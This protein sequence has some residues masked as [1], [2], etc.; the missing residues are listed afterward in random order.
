MVSTPRGFS[1]I[2]L[3]MALTITLGIGLIVFQLF[4][5]N[6]HVFRDQ[7][8]IIEM[9]QSA[10]AVASQIA[11][12]IRMA[13]TGIPIYA[14]IADIEFEDAVA[15]ILPTSTTSRID[16]RAGL[17]NVEAM[18]TTAAPVGLAIGTPI[19]LGVTGASFSA[20]QHVYLWGPSTPS[21]WSWV[22]ASISGATPTAVTVMPLESGTRAAVWFSQ[23]PSIS[24]EEA[25]SFFL[26]GSAIKRAA[27]TDTT[28]PL[29][30]VWSAANEI[31]RNFT[32]LS[33]AYFDRN[34]RPV[35]PDSLANRMAVARVDVRLTA[36]T[37]EPLTNGER[38]AYSVSL[39]ILP[40]NLRLRL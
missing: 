19:A 31:G 29:S 15:A 3:T 27:A 14:S 13:G 22:R 37:A 28:D 10:R 23:S 26:S 21:T 9:Q 18:V 35:V 2:E 24:L 16:F 17:S 7:H 38:P 5:Q 36:Q 4:Q 11:D 6:E 40:R 39:R 1:L 25:V 8:L 30:P 12:E 33:F 20:G 32:S 34:D